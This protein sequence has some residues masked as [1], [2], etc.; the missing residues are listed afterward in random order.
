MKLES[1]PAARQVIIWDMDGV[2]VDSAQLHFR[3]WR[4]A[5]QHYKVGYTYEDFRHT[6]GQKNENAIRH[7]LGPGV[8][9]ETIASIAGEKE[10]CFRSLI[11]QGELQ[12]FPGAKKLIRDLYKAGFPMALASSAPLENIELILKSLRLKPCF[13]AI[14][15][16][17]DVTEGKPDPQVFL[18]AAR[19]L[20]A[21][22]RDCL[23]IEDAVAGV[24]A[25]KRAG[26]KC[27]AVTNTSPTGS[28]NQAD[29]VIDAL[30]QLTVR[31]IGLLL[32]E[33]GGASNP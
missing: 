3:S 24:E 15:S 25:A 17:E 20:N 21:A 19:R 32:S 7:V 4:A 29:L 30:K 23:V 28:L 12:I 8:S 31:T 2:I 13:S 18:L 33:Q 26:M 1:P 6:F 5:F 11:R 22:P 14:V 10:E 9:P 16:G 27:V